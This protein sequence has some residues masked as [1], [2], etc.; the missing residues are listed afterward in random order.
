MKLG[1]VGGAGAMGGVWANR[2]ARA[3]NDVAILDVAPAA[4]EAIGRDGL[5][6][7][8]KDGT[9]ETTSILATADPTAI[10]VCDAV[11]FFPKGTH[12]AAAAELA[13][14]LVDTRTTVVSLQNG[15]GNSDVLAGVFDPAQL[16]M[17]VTYHSATVK[18]PGRVAH[19]NSSRT[20]IGPYVDGAPLDRAQ[21]LGD[22]M[23]EA[24]IPTEVT[25]QVKT[26]IWKKV[27]L[28]C[29]TLPTASFTRLTS[30]LMGKSEDVLLVCDALA[31]ES[32]AV[33]QAMGIPGIEAEERTT[34]IRNLLGGAGP[35]K[36]SMLQDVEAGRKTEIDTINGA[37]VREG[38]KH[39]VAT[40][41]NSAMVG[42]V[43]GLE[44]SY[45]GSGS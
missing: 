29:A 27:I 3:G 38:A 18:A 22:A 10:G 32:C 2:L 25:P 6:V 40:P 15:W 33:A 7:E 37:I 44:R 16:V 17:G 13:R 28:N 31:T 34:F 39:G 43:R 19:T 4:L 23:T 30:D 26:E 8:N 11:I 21:A 45:L 12:T 35:G 36:A 42:L 1:I 24:G 14:P 5:V 41:L 9:V 20:V